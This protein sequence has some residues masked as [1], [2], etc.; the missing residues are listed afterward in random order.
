MLML[1]C[2]LHA[3]W[4]MLLAY[5][6]ADSNKFRLARTEPGHQIFVAFITCDWSARCYHI[7][8]GIPNHF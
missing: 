5:E 6:T 3:P 4:S 2:G 1:S 7:E 8:L